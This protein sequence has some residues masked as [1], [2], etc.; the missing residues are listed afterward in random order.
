VFSAFPPLISAAKLCYLHRLDLLHFLRR[1]PRSFLAE[2]VFLLTGIVRSP[3][4]RDAHLPF[5]IASYPE[6]PTLAKPTD[7]TITHDRRTR[8]PPLPPWLSYAARRRG[9]RD[10]ESCDSST[11]LVSGV[12]DEAR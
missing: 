3:P 2:V 5:N 6:K 12:W 11:T 9:D 7:R 4:T 1:L 8:Q 10:I